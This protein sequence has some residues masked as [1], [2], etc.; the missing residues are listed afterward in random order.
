MSHIWLLRLSISC[1]IIVLDVRGG[2]SHPF[3]QPT[4]YHAK[5]GNTQNGHDDAGPWVC[6]S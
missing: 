3:G 1:S 5:Q 4:T 2:N 6:L